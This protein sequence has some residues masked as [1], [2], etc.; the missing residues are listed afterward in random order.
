MLVSWTS[1]GLKNASLRGTSSRI[2]WP[3]SSRNSTSS[4]RNVWPTRKAAWA[5]SLAMPGLTDG[6]Y[7]A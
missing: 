2:S 5:N 1:P 3:P 7:P 6:L 4:P